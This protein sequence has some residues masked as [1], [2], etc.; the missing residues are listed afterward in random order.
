MIFLGHSD[1]FPDILGHS[2]PFPNMLGWPFSWY[3]WAAVT[4]FSIDWQRA[5]LWSGLPA[6]HSNER[7][8]RKRVNF[9][10]YVKMHT[11]PNVIVAWKTI[12]KHWKVGVG[13]ITRQKNQSYK[14]PAHKFR[15]WWWLHDN[16]KFSLERGNIISVE[17]ETVQRKYICAY[18]CWCKFGY[19]EARWFWILH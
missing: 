1:P 6:P 18:W 15:W 19:L 14:W 8:G 2:D 17:M 10:V 3:S 5:L 16:C 9:S 11:G 7:E 4:L 13:E 12:A